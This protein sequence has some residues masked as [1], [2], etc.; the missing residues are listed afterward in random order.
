M[1]LPTD[2][3]IQLSSWTLTSRPSPVALK[4]RTWICGYFLFTHC[5][6][7]TKF[8]EEIIKTNYDRQYLP[9]WSN[10]VRQM[11]CP[12]TLNHKIRSM[13]L[14]LCPEWIMQ[15]RRSPVHLLPLNIV[16]T[17]SKIQTAL[18]RWCNRPTVSIRTS[19]SNV[20]TSPSPKPKIA[21]VSM[22]SS[23]SNLLLRCAILPATSCPD[24]D[25]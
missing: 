25:D 21:P 22:R 23:R 11:V 15:F 13:S 6:S 17:D 4:L 18:W 2:H 19:Y 20:C 24:L 9:S 5:Q 10:G 7:S 12:L 1:R 3:L 8:T 14:I 16:E